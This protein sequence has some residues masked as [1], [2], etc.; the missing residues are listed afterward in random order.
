MRFQMSSLVPVT[1]L[2]VSFGTDNARPSH[3]CAQEI[4]RP[5][6]DISDILGHAL[7]LT[8]SFPWADADAQGKSDH[9]PARISVQPVLHPWSHPQMDH[10]PSVKMDLCL[11]FFDDF[12]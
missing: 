9:H 10:R 1:S 8:V 5:L 12:D 3:H 7:V 6:H 2:R 4:P 11:T